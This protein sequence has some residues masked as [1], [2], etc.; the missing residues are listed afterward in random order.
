MRTYKPRSTYRRDRR[1]RAVTLRAGGLSLRQIA[2]KIGA[3][4][5]TVRRDLSAWDEQQEK[6]SQL[7]VT[8]VAPGGDECDTGCDSREAV[9]IP[10]RRS[11]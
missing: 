8:K 5:E 10:L 1:D 9:V 3:S 6:V 7:P 4:H 2:A 11:S